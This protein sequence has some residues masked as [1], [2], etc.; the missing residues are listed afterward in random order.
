VPPLLHQTGAPFRRH[1]TLLQIFTYIFK[2]LSFL[3][4]LNVHPYWIMAPY[5]CV[6][7]RG[8]INCGNT[9]LLLQ[10]SHYVPATDQKPANPIYQHVKHR[11]KESRISNVWTVCVSI[12]LLACWNT[13]FQQRIPFE[14]KPLDK[15]AAFSGCGA[16]SSADKWSTF[17][18]YCVHTQL[19]GRTR[20]THATEKP[21]ASLASINLPKPLPLLRS[22]CL[23]LVGT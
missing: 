2:C 4:Q 16:L 5:F 10:L 1:W 13:C 23:H 20:Y 21:Q 22:H 12:R 19:K 9:V 14:C 8:G 17:Y 15:A 18:I 7:W 11:S 3:G 6:E